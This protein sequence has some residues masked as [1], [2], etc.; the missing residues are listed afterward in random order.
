[1]QIKILLSIDQS[2]ACVAGTTC[3]VNSSCSDV[4]TV[5]LFFSPLHPRA[6]II[7]DARPLGTFKNQDSR[8]GKTWY[9]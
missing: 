8:D 3:S 2:N 9:V 5:P 6:I 4:I 7:P 1:M